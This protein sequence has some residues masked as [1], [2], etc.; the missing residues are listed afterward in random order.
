MKIHQLTREMFF[1]DKPVFTHM[2][3][4]DMYETYHAHTFIEFVYVVSGSCRH[5][6]NGEEETALAGD[7]YLFM[8]E[9]AHGYDNTNSPKMIH[10]DILIAND[11][12]QSVCDSLTPHLYTQLVSKKYPKKFRL[13]ND[14]ISIIENTIVNMQTETEN[15]EMYAKLLT[16]TILSFVVN[17]TVKK[18]YSTMPQWLVELT[19]T[20]S[21]PNVLSWQ[22]DDVL[23]RF[24]L[25]RAYMCRVFKKF[26]GTTMTEFFNRQ[27]MKYAYHLICNT[28]DTI[29]SISAD[30]GFKNLTHFYRMF[31]RYFGRTPNSL[32]K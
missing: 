14:Q 27:K 11:F 23:E 28:N 13:S 30:V 20:L 10:R 18:N 25:N 1:S 19:S 29:A 5:I 24:K 15:F 3:S 12:F 22:L 21:A 16:Y 32:R 26:T 2:A 9:D 17:H 6:V 8:L 31:Q 4:V 7:A